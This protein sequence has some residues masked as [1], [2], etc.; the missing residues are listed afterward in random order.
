MENQFKICR[1][2]QINTS[3]DHKFRSKVCI[4]CCSKMNNEKLKSVGYYNK[5]YLEHKILGLKRGR[6]VKKVILCLED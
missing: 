5:Y 3:Q 6:P 4:K 1:V 2:C